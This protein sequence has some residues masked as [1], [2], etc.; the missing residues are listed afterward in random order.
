M[1]AKYEFW[2]T[3]DAG[4]RITL[5]K[6]FAF[7]NYSRT[8][9]G[10]GTIQLGIPYDF[11]TSKVSN[12]FQPDWRIDVWR[13]PSEGYALR[14][15]ASYFLRKYGIYQRTTDN[16]RMVEFIGRSPLDIL[17]RASVI[18]DTAAKYSKTDF[19]DDMMKAI[20]TDNFITITTFA[21]VGEFIVEG[22]LS[23]GPSVSF[24]FFGRVVLDVLK[25]LKAN[26]FSLNRAAS[27]NRRI[28]F[29]VVEGD[30][31]PGGFGY[32]FRTYADLRG[33]DRTK[34]AVFSIENGNLR[35]PAYYEDYLD[36]ATEARVYNQTNATGVTVDSPDVGLSRWN[37]IQQFQ[38]ATG[39]VVAEMTATANK[40]LDENGLKASMNA[41]FANTPG[42][43]V[44]PR[45]LYGVDWDLGDLLPVSFGGKNLSCEVMIV[46]VSVDDKG[47]EN[48]VGNT[49]VGI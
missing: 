29:D 9:Q 25:D 18:T 35:A 27:T 15:E 26:S 2:L 36:Q 4:R 8:S 44:Q 38:G 43:D 37:T 42:N 10:Y 48:I 24:S 39:A 16:V 47:T 20:V 14:R 41:S 11:Y 33:L 12:T 17:R 19:I 30:G 45:S 3:D 6:E 28:F 5:L 40:I 13:S 22:D 1:T 7:A 31:L 23:L 32:I 21:P 49:E 34:G 46:H